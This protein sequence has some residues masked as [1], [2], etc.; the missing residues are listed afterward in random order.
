MIGER[1][2]DDGI[3]DPSALGV[4]AMAIG[5]DHKIGIVHRERDP[6]RLPECEVGYHPQPRGSV[7]DVE[8]LLGVGIG[9]VAPVLDHVPVAEH[10]TGLLADT[11]F[12]NRVTTPYEYLDVEG[13]RNPIV[14]CFHRCTINRRRAQASSIRGQRPC[15]L[16]AARAA[17]LTPRFVV[18]R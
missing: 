12:R 17:A 5:R 6:L 3:H 10:G 4:H 7:A 2:A 11:G 14:T 18:V 15:R 16:P 9:V 1:S 13:Y 8:V